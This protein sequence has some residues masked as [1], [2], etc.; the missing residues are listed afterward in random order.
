MER[1]EAASPMPPGRA[2]KSSKT[3]LIVLVQIFLV[4]LIVI[5]TVRWIS[6]SNSSEQP[7]R[8]VASGGSSSPSPGVAPSAPGVPQKLGGVNLVDALTG[9]EAVEDMSMLHGKG[10][11]LVGGWVGHYQSKGIAFVGEAVDEKGAAQLLEAM[12]QRIGAGNATF[13]NLRDSVIDG[14]KAYSVTGQGQNHYFYQK[15]NKVIW[16]TL[17]TN[18]PEDFLRDALQSID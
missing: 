15:G 4:L 6:G 3:K 11:G 7:I 13:R 2:G 18:K 12:V 8:S 1:G 9:Q 14:Q 5:A 17:P 16:L 10:V